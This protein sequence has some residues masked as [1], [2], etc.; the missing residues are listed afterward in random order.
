MYWILTI[1]LTAEEYPLICKWTSSVHE[2]ITC[3]PSD[4]LPSDDVV[5]FHHRGV[6]FLA[7]Y[8]LGRAC[9]VLGG[10]SRHNRDHR[11]TPKG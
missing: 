6:A 8:Q 2:Y 5:V 11:N 1:K 3:N 7:T 10:H 4:F 9:G